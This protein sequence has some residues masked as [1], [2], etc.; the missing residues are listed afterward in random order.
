MVVKYLNHHKHNTGRQVLALLSH[1]IQIQTARPS[2]SR[3]VLSD[4][5]SIRFGDVVV[6]DSVY[7]DLQ[8]LSSEQVVEWHAGIA[9]LLR[10]YAELRQLLFRG[11]RI[12]IQAKLVVT[13]KD[14]HVEVS[15]ST[16]ELLRVQTLALLQRY[17]DRLCMCDCGQLFVRIGKRRFCSAR[18]QM[19][20]WMREQRAIERKERPGT[21]ETKRKGDRYGTTRK[22]R[23]IHSSS[24]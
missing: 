3:R 17:G 10:E 11:M 19:R 12:E 1:L 8:V 2:A 5:V 14:S 6:A 7:E 4:L 16:E 23:R 9:K 15:G 13:T 21:E 24:R 22:G 20:V 18:C